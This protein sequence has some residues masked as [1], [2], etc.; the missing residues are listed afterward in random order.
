MKIILA[1][2]GMAVLLVACDKSEDTP[3]GM[4]EFSGTFVGTFSRTGM[5]TAAVTI[6]F[7]DNKFSGQSVQSK[8]PAICRGS[9]ALHENTITFT[10]SCVWTA[11]FDWTLILNGNYNISFP[12][13][14]DVRIWR[15]SGAV[16]DEYL[17]RKLTR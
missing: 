10:D 2:L 7:G 3:P 1:W 14:N 13:E 12:A 6:E 16:T 17:V 4:G 11:D 8:Y 15:T 9:F 5:D